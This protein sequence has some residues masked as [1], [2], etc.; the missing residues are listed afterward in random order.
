MKLHHGVESAV[1][2]VD[3]TVSGTADAIVTV[4]SDSILVT[5]YATT[6][7]GTVDV[8]VYAITQGGP[9]NSD[10]A[11]EALLFSFPQLSAPSGQ[12]LLQTAAATTARVRVKA[13]WTGAAHFD[14]NARAINGG[15]SNTRV[16]AA[17]TAVTD[18]KTVNTGAPQ[19]LIPP[20]LVGGIGFLVK[21]WS[22]N[23][24]LIYVSEDPS[25]IPNQAWVLTPG[26]TFDISVKS[27][28]TWYTAS[29]VD[30]ANLR[31]VRGEQ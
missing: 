6:V 21:N 24:A 10:A 4:Q 19:I 5:L 23:G 7:G 29:T 27:G 17:S 11:H 3:E 2:R 14:V 30:G 13:T 15:A 16:I 31:I 12:L 26:E 1:L 20:S 25:K 18:S 8:D 9:G 28:Q 22:S